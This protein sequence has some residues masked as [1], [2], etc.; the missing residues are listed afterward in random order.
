MV[1]HTTTV[2][3]RDTERMGISNMI[4]KRLKSVKQSVASDHRLEWKCSIEF[5]YLNIHA[6]DATKF[7]LLIK[8]S[9]FIKPDQRQ[10][11]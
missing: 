5:V 10:L 3:T 6:C 11:K 2:F 8:K 1:K 9:S 4:R 7:I